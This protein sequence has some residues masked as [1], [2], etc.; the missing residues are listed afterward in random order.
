MDDLPVNETIT[1]PGGELRISFARSGG[2]GGQNVNKVESKVE[3]RWTPQSSAAL[4]DRDR[5]WLL[6]RLRT[7]LTSAGDL[8]VT[9]NRTRD[10]I[11]N[12]EDALEKMA[13]AVRSA[14]ERPKP[15]RKT[16]PTRGAIEGRLQEKKQ[17]SRLKKDRPAIRHDEH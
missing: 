3:L 15:R 5:A 11:R 16:R 6:H 9:S 2:P 7:K 14:L 12:R 13:A 17:R 1:I 8:V 4:G 10:Q